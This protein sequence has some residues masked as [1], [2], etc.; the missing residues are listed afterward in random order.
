MQIV[1]SSNK[2]I[3]GVG[4]DFSNYVSDSLSNKVTKYFKNAVSAKVNFV[5]RHNV[6]KTSIIVNQG[7]GHNVIIDATANSANIDKSF[8][9]ALKK[10][11]FR[12]CKYKEKIMAH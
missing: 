5:K 3:G 11:S 1:I 12:L 7:A 10:L 2:V 4:G 8:R 9:L 6:F